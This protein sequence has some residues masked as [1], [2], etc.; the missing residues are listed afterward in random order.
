MKI[1]THITDAVTTTDELIPSG[2]TS[3]YRSNPLRLAEFTLSRKDPK[4]VE[5]SKAVYKY[6]LA[7]DNGENPEEEFEELKSVYENIRKIEGF[8]NIDP[9]EIGI[10][11]TMYAN[12]PGD[13][14][15]RE[16]AASSQR[17]LGAW[18][19]IAKEY[20]TKRYR[21]NLLNWGIIPFLIEDENLVKKDDFV[22]VPNVR[23]A[24]LTGNDNIKAYVLGDTIKEIKLSV[25][26]L[27]ND[28]K[29]ILTSGSLIN[30]NKSN[31]K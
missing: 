2:E 9:L 31:L 1:V 17:V 20:A 8:N 14:S 18:A 28:E 5:N 26:Q 27:T 15:A 7:R 29:Q 30:F 16:Q 10:G 13:G 11:S 19:N 3:S 25:G 12:K 6:E 24:I 22:F 21:S 4:Y 23:E